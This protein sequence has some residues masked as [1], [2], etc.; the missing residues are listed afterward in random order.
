MLALL[1]TRRVVRIDK[2]SKMKKNVI[3]FLSLE[4][5]LRIEES[6]GMSFI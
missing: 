4:G 5:N 6:L 1:S 3:K 2:T